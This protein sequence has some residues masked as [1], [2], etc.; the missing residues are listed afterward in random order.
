MLII[1]TFDNCLHKLTPKLIGTTSL[2]IGNHNYKLNNLIEDQGNT[3]NRGHYTAL[4]EYN[5]K[6]LL[7]NHMTIMTTK[8]AQ[9]SAN[10][11]MLFYLQT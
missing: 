8:L 6:W 2:K 4:V 5:G 10:S 7:Y 1:R 9:H 11:Y 3:M